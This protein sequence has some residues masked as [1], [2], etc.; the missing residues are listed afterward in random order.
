MNAKKCDR[1]GV[2]YEPKYKTAIADA[3]ESIAKSFATF[4]EAQARE[5]TEDVELK[6]DLCPTCKNDLKEWFKNG[7]YQD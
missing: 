1:C 5:F 6:F 7:N 2:F 3:L 4:T